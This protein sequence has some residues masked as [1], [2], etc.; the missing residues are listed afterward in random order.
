MNSSTGPKKIMVLGSSGLTG[1][2]VATLLD[3]VE[4]VVPIRTSRDRTRVSDWESQGK[5]ARFISMIRG[6]SRMRWREPI[7]SSSC[8]P[9]RSA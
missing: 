4:G 3:G 9:T 7:A 1:G 5:T 8:Q 6:P 2:A